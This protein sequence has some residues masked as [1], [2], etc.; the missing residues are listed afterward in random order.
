[1]KTLKVNSLKVFLYILY[2]NRGTELLQNV[3]GNVHI[4]CRKT[5]YEKSKVQI[6][7][8]EFNRNVGPL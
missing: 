1:M 7:N 4:S 6:K 5:I 3:L 2:S 8:K